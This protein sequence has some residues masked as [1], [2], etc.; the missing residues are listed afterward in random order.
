MPPGGPSPSPASEGTFPGGRR[1]GFD[2]NDVT[3][4]DTN[5]VARTE[6]ET[7]GTILASSSG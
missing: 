5:R 6:K 3:T 7:C 4:T 1:C 2:A